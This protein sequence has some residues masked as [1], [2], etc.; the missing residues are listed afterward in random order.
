MMKEYPAQ[1]DFRFLEV[2]A[3]PRQHG[4][5]AGRKDF[6]GIAI[7]WSLCAQGSKTEQ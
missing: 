6:A 5:I 3:V 7:C 1:C 2:A 4:F